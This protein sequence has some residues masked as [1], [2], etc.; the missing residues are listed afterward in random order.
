MSQD[1]PNF[2][3]ISDFSVIAIVFMGFYPQRALEKVSTLS[4]KKYTHN[5]DF[6]QEVVH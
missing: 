2:G 1:L 6:Y 3:A 4:E 5:Y